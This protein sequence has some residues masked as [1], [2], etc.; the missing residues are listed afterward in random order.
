M[1]IGYDQGLFERKDLGNYECPVCNLIVRFPRQ[2]NK[3]QTLFCEE[4]SKLIINHNKQTW[5]C[6]TRCQNAEL[7][8]L[9]KLAQRSYSN[10]IICCEKCQKKMRLEDYIQ[11]EPGCV[12][13]IKGSNKCKNY[14]NCQQSKPNGEEGLYCSRTCEVVCT[15]REKG[16]KKDRYEFVKE[17]IMN[18]TIWCSDFLNNGPDAGKELPGVGP[19]YGFRWSKKHSSPILKI[20]NMDMDVELDDQSYSFRSVNSERGFM[21]GVHYWEIEV[22]PNS[23]NEMKIGVSKKNAYDYN[24]AFCDQSF[25]WGFYGTGTT[26]HDSNTKGKPYG[27]KLKNEGTLCILLDMNRGR[28][29]FGIKKEGKEKNWGVAFEV[30]D[31]KEGPLYPAVSLIHKCGF[32]THF[33]KKIPDF[34]A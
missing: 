19:N 29:S 15:Y 16:I 21:E 7:T 30:P 10:L 32:K 33:P 13:Q 17:M 24:M 22:N 9:S 5:V 12:H 4:C 3:C 26:R 23:E 6:T 14:F 1:D 34:M 11:H 2:C 31:L 28:L 27:E 20:S 8:P 25:G 18:P